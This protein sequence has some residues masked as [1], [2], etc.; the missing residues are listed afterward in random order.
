MVIRMRASLAEEE[1]TIV[2]ESLRRELTL[3]LNVDKLEM[4]KTTLNGGAW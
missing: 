3:N 2:K 1:I 4:I